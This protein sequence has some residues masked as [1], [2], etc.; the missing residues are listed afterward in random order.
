MESHC[1]HPH[2]RSVLEE[3]QHYLLQVAGLAA[4]TCAERL[5]QAQSFLEHHFP[6][7]PLEWSR[8]SGSMVLEYVLQ[9]QAAGQ[10]V[11]LPALASGLRSLLRFLRLSGHVRLELEAAV[12]RVAHV[13]SAPPPK[14]LSQ[15][16]V[17]AMLAMAERK[18]AVGK[19]DYAILLCLARLGLRPGEVAGLSLADLNW[20]GATVRLTKTKGCRESL[21]PLSQAVGQA[22]VAYLRGRPATPLECVFVSFHPLPVALKASQ[23]SQIARRAIAQVPGVGPSRGASLLRHTFATHLVQ[24][25]ATLKA[26]ADLLRHRQLDTTRVYAKV[27]VPMLA[28]LALPWPEVVR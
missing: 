25:G 28:S 20:K 23:V 1:S 17:Q 7:A 24:K 19:R 12:P 8:L 21:L 11:G 3:Y 16:Q 6:A 9:A 13:P 5:R 26:V 15:E 18:T 27:N 22:L 4:L 2:L 14:Y 10:G